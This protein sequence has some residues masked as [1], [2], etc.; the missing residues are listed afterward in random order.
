M[1]KQAFYLLRF[2]NR[3]NRNSARSLLVHRFRSIETCLP[4]L[5]LP[6]C[7]LGLK[8]AATLTICPHKYMN[9]FLRLV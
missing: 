5:A 3:N 6:A 9:L 8:I 1:M 2:F 4:Y 7:L